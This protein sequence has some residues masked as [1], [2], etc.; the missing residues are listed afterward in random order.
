MK[1]ARITRKAPRKLGV[2]AHDQ[3][4]KPRKLDRNF[5]QSKDIHE[6]RGTIQSHLSAGAVGPKGRIGKR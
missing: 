3:A 6:D 4:A 5:K 2:E 1:K